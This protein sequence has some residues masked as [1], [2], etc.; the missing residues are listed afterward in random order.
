MIRN[1]LLLLC[2]FSVVAQANPAL[3][4][5]KRLGMN[6]SA[7]QELSPAEKL[8]QLEDKITAL[9]LAA[10]GYNR[11]LADL[12]AS[13][14]NFAKQQQ[15]ATTPLQVQGEVDL[16]Q[17]ASLA[18]LQLSELKESEALL[19]KQIATQLERQKQL[20]GLIRDAR[21][22]ALQNQRTTLLPADTPS[23]ALQHAQRRLY[24]QQL[25]TLEAELDSSPARLEMAQMRLQLV[26]AQLHQQEQLMEVLNQA[27]AAQQMSNT[28]R[29]LANNIIDD[30]QLTDPLAIDINR[31]NLELGEQLRALTQDIN[32]TLN[33]QARAETRYQQQAKQLSNIQEQIT[34]VKLN[35]AFGDRFLQ[36]LQALPKPPSPEKLQGEIADTRLAR[37]HIEQLQVANQQQLS[38]DSGGAEQ[39]KLLV[40]QQV[41]IGKL[42]EA[43]DLYLTELAKLKLSYEQLKQ[44]YETLR[45]TLNEHLFWVPNANAIGKLWLTELQRSSVWLVEQAPWYELPKALDEQQFLW[46]W[47][48]ILLVTCLM[49]QDL[50][51]PKFKST[52]KRYAAHVGNVTQDNFTFT[53]KALLVSAGY[54]LI[55]PMPI[56]AAGLIFY[57]ATHNFVQAVGMGIVAMGCLQLLYRFYRLLSGE[58]GVLIAHFGRPAKM[59]QDITSRLRRFV[60]FAT[61]LLGLMGFTEV[62]DSSPIRNSL[63]RGAFII[64]CI[65]L[66]LLYKDA[67]TISRKFRQSTDEDGKNKQLLHRVL[68]LALL[69]V[70]LASAMLAILGY[71]FTAFQMLLQLQL[72][73]VVGLSFLLA[74]QLIRRWM[75]I[76]RRR[77]AFDRAK[78]RR[79]EILAQRGKGE[80]ANN[81][82][83]DT[84]E[85]PV[86][87]LE[88]I[89]SQ[90]LGLVRSL[91][92]LALLASLIGL[93]SQTHTALFSFLDGVTLWTSN[94]VINGIEQ[95]VP[96]TLKSV[97]FGLIIFAF[98]MMIATNLPGLLELMI[99]QR[100]DLTPGTGFAITTVSR[101][102]V[103][104]FGSLVGFSTLGM[105]WSKLQWLIAALS[106]GLGFG[107]QEIFAN[108]ISGLIILFEKPVRIGDTVT[109]RELT[110]TVSKIQIRATTI[111][112]WDRKEIIV[113]NK[114][115][116]TEQLINWS[117][118]DPITRVIINVSVAR[119]SDPAKVEASLYQAVKEC[120]EALDVPEPE[121][122]F[123]GFGQHTQ[124]YEVRAYAKD[125]NARWP[126]R[127]ALHKLI[128][129]KLK[130]NNL[131]LAYPQLE[132]HLNP[133]QHRDAGQGLI[134]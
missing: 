20:P 55:W 67:L 70:P 107:L 60:W 124:D 53:F 72:S 111:V 35:S 30:A 118:S 95:Q 130:E 109:I 71:Y 22:S 42:L 86:V 4:L 120:N 36:M 126:L 132:I 96:V 112:D 129:G 94:S 99:L 97:F 23:G 66:F 7:V 82:Q 125:M 61:P 81:E 134:R 40:S 93:W 122:W 32:Q 38:L 79:A 62:L 28:D 41:L 2:L 54:S 113:P 8:S 78:A 29:T 100:L 123:A 21:D 33:A 101:Y 63:G 108:F 69:L 15:D 85:E 43:Y 16:R 31:V 48:I 116:I 68:W 128:S 13:R 46:A 24:Q 14:H 52:L 74:Y 1:I 110:G 6:N 58:K 77:I 9:T 27:I 121:V 115:F 84:Y 25:L 131:E 105:E 80:S 3:G 119:D 11:A 39:Q 106:V 88:T 114:A 76:E 37:Y 65:F 91:L 102:L 75:L 51:A 44:Q 83:P 92:L 45:S 50:L 64:F 98:S 10:E 5:D 90:S 12:S 89:S 73:L 103:V 133:Q 59:V 18:H 57:E 34:W 104:L 19:S 56:I 47:W 117:L 49:V 87:D 26:R 17:Q 127:H